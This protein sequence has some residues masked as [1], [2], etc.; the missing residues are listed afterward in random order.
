MYSFIY[1]YWYNMKKIKGF[2]EIEINVAE[3]FSSID[4]AYYIKYAFF[5]CRSEFK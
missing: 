1:I 5:K 4:F 3:I 2:I